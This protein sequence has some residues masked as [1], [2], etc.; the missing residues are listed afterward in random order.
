MME[1][2]FREYSFSYNH[3]GAEWSL[4]VKASSAEDARARIAKLA[5]ARYDGE[6]I[7]VIPSSVGLL[8]RVAVFVRNLLY[9]SR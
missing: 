2:P 7:A 1:A 3:D 4:R 5:W 9:G 8:G 6:V